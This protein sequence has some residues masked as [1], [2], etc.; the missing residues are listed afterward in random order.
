MIL[1]FSMV[2]HLACSEVMYALF[3]LNHE[4]FAVADV[5]ALRGVG[6]AAALEVEEG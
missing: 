3:S 6:D 5:E 2:M 1:P 4:L